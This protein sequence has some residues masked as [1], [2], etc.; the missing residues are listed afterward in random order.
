[1]MLAACFKTLGR[2]LGLAVCAAALAAGVNVLR[3]K[4][5]PW[6][7]DWSRY[8]ETKALELGL[9]L[10]SADT[11]VRARL[12]E[13]ALLF[14]ARPLEEYER[15]HVP[16][17]LALPVDDVDLHLGDYMHLMARETLLLTYCS[18]RDCDDGILLA[19][20]LREQR[21]TNVAVFL[22]GLAEWKA[23]GRPTATG[24]P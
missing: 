7:Q 10:A 23:E 13:E 15:E 20:Y 5:L 21:F 11:V 16:G 24:T 22:G 4:P 14:D 6:V 19:Q 12:G 18:G 2:A 8:L 3:A 9:P 17:A 1:M